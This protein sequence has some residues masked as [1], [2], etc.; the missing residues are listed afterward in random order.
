MS[1]F[2]ANGLVATPATFFASKHEPSPKPI[3]DP[4]NLER[5]IKAQDEGDIFN[6]VV[7]AIREGHRKPQP[8]TWM[9][10]VFP[11]MDKCR[12]RERRRKRRHR[13]VWPRGQALTSLDE[14]RA[15][16]KHPILGPRIREAAHAVL[17]SPFTDCFTVM[18]S[19]SSL[20]VP[21]ETVTVYLRRLTNE[22]E[23]DNMFRD[24][25]RLHSSV[26]IFRQAARYPKCFHETEHHVGENLVFRRVI[27]RYFVDFSD[28]DQEDDVLDENNRQLLKMYRG[29]RHSPTTDRLNALE[30]E[31]IEKRLA[32]S[33]GCVCKRSK[34][35]LELL[36]KGAKMQIM[37][38]VQFRELREAKASGVFVNIPGVDGL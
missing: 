10:F 18:V 17:D 33:E 5:F 25:E 34:E 12:T 1:S 30:L 2:T 37:T 4:F 27:D 36:D 29:K 24:T 7:A 28:S 16:L 32:K 31:A 9:W 6:R 19:Y 14:A 22:F 13:D 38:D 20:F 21:C 26:T 23:Q 35:E 11:Q 8:A 3:P 15:Y